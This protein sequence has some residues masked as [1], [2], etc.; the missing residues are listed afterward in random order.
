[1]L[2]TIPGL[3]QGLVEVAVAACGEQRQPGTC[4]AAVHALPGGARPM[5]G[6]PRTRPVSYTNLRAHETKANLASRLLLE[7][8]HN[9]HQT[10]L[11]S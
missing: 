4:A 5:P 7:K 8:K 11:A 9:S 10:A 2:A 1:M 6:D 3:P